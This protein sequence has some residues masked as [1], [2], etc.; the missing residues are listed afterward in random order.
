MIC[1][2]GLPLPDLSLQAHIISTH[3]VLS[4]RIDWRSTPRVARMHLTLWLTECPFIAAMQDKSKSV[5]I[6]EVIHYFANSTVGRTS[7]IHPRPLS[8]EAT[9]LFHEIPHPQNSILAPC[10][11]PRLPSKP[12]T[13][14][15]N[16]KF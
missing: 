10:P 14:D 15:D 3:A 5:E 16:P 1:R 7:S 8:F 9:R 12:L 11:Y 2:W 13:Q 4:C 6:Q